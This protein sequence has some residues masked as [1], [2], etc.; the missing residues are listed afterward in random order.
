MKDVVSLIIK[1]VKSAASTIKNSSSKSKKSIFAFVALVAIIASFCCSDT[2][3]AYN[4]N[5]KGNIIAT[6]GSK[7]Q[8][9][10]A[11]ALVVNMVGDKHIENV[12]D[13]P[14]FN[15]TV[16]LS[17]NINNTAEV[18]DAIINN[19][20]EI[21]EATTL[22]VDGKEVLRAKKDVVDS[23]INERLNKFNLEGENCASHF[24]NDIITQNDYF[25]ISELDDEQKAKEVINSLSVITELTQVTTVMVPY[26][27]TV[28]TTNEQ[29]VGYKKVTVKGASGVD[30]V[31]NAI[32]MVNGEIK[33]NTTLSTETVVAPINEVTVKGTAKNE[34]SAKEK[35]IAHN[36]GFTFPLPDG[37]WRVSSYYGDGRRHK[38]VDICAKSGTSIYAVLDG[39]VVLSKWNGN[40]GYCV[41]IEHE[42]GT[43]TLYAHAKQLCCSV[44]DK[45]SQ[46]DVIALVGTTGQS[47]GN[48]LHFEV[49]AGGR[50]VDPA[51]YI[52]LD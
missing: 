44:G 40:Y 32:V 4:V 30:R 43:R 11:R 37:T 46:G 27:S 21:V 22:F 13:E 51:P 9:K 23:L 42:N 19:T 49:I 36:A 31:T 34:A 33:S 15:T 17:S 3:I 20:D 1:S 5:Y 26:E 41:I 35:Q 12:V 28:E 47:T 6:V 50:N 24:E 10:H 45:V 48:H 25:V 2:R 14:V 18:A 8:F 16:V 39:T 29:V 38:G 52:N 7:Q